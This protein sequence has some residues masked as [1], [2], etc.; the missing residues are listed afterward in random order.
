METAIKTIFT[1]VLELM[2]SVE[3]KMFNISFNLLDVL[4][5]SLIMTALVW[6]LKKLVDM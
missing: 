1:D 3:F 4:I 2:K 5:W 6:F